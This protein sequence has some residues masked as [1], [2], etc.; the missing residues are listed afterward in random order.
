MATTLTE[1]ELEFRAAAAL[2]ALSRLVAREE[3]KKAAKRAYEYADAMLA[4]RKGS[5]EVGG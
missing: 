5:G 1:E 4:A 3:P 2:A